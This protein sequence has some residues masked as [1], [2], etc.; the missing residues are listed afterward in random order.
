MYNIEYYL[1][2]YQGKM[3]DLIAGLEIGS[4]SVKMVVAQQVAGPVENGHGLQVIGVAEVPAYG[5][6]KGV[7]NNIEDAVSSV[8]ACLENVERMTGQQISHVWVGVSGT[9]IISQESRGIVAVSRPSGEIQ[10]EDIER[11]IDAARTVA[12]PLNYEILHVVPRSFT[13]DGQIGVKDPTGMTGIRLEVDTQIIQGLSSHIKNLTKCIYRT[14]L[15]IEDIVLS[16]LAGSEAVLDK[17]QKELGCVLINIGATTTSMVV[18]EDGDVIHTAIIPVG[19][20]HITS[21]LAI[22]LRTAI[23]IAD[24]VKIEFGSC[25][26]ADFDEHDMINLGELGDEDTSVKRSYVAQIIEA[27]VEEIFEKVDYEL[28]R[29]GRSSLLPAGAVLVGGGAKLPGIVSVA[30][31]QLRLPASLGYPKFLVTA[32]DRVNDV[33]YANV[34]G[35]VLWADHVASTGKKGTKGFSMQSVTAVA[36]KIKAIFKSFMP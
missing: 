12:T 33:A 2:N 5:I 6:K 18:F 15:E 26:P 14:G 23:D 24:R 10:D 16:I 29:I 9:H 8:S 11:A 19:A 17:R 1:T 4:H 31:K 13:V 36:D 27:R 3:G 32:I 28:K 20:D 35:L 21:D 25:I 7:V 30:K 34:I 22:G